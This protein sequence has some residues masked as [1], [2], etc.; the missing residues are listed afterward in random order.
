M[1]EVMTSYDD[2]AQVSLASHATLPSGPPLPDY[3]KTI[4][5]DRA[6]SESFALNSANR[7]AVL[8]QQGGNGGA[9]PGPYHPRPGIVNLAKT[10]LEHTRGSGVDLKM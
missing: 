3:L 1:S 5:D 6:F 7:Y 9:K 8:H 10:F 4:H 2:F